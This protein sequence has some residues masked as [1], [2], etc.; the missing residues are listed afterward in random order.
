MRV[1]RTPREASLPCRPAFF[2]AD[3]GGTILISGRLAVACNFAL[4]GSG[5]VSGA[6]VNDPTPAGHDYAVWRG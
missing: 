3:T 2:T 5:S 4:G 6:I 1:N